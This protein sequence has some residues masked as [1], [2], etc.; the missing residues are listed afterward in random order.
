MTQ[1]KS[2]EL[3]VNHLADSLADDIDKRSRNEPHEFDSRVAFVGAGMGMQTYLNLGRLRC[4]LLS[5]VNR[6][7]FFDEK[8]TNV[9]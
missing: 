4:S 5:L 8:R 2:K 3:Y 6:Y 9:C 7:Q 1:N